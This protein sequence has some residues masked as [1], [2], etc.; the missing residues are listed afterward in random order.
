MG[1]RR[2]AVAVFIATSV[3]GGCSSAESSPGTA[4]EAPS[5][6]AFASERYGYRLTLPNGWRR[7]P[8]PGRWNGALYPGDPGVD[9]FVDPA[10]ARRVFVAARPVGRAVT[11]ARWA[12]TIAAGVPAPCGKALS[13]TRRAFAG[14]SA[15]IATYECSDGY[16]AINAT[17][18]RDRRGFAVGWVSPAGS[19]AADQTQFEA[20][21][22]SLQFTNAD[23][24]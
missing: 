21:L 3:V 17:L 23:A 14:T 16:I 6:E 11:P 10:A 12:A 9:T 2:V 19:L 13:R 22:R 4:P 18:I 15:D 5:R 1:S 8:T 24:S 7:E 20:V